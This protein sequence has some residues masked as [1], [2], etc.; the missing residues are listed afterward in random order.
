M[1]LLTLL[2]MLLVLP[3]RV[4]W[5]QTNTTTQVGVGTFEI[6]EKDVEDVANRWFDTSAIKLPCT[7]TLF[8][9]N[10]DTLG[11]VKVEDPWC[12]VATNWRDSLGTI[13]WGA[14]DSIWLPIQDTTYWRVPCDCD[15][16]HLDE[17]WRVMSVEDE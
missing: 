10:P 7:L 6:T 16:S 12:M 11:F 4:T 8:H 15:S 9:V 2:I 14:L 17:S 1:K 3:W 5:A 13:H